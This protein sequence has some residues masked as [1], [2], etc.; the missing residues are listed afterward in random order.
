MEIKKLLEDSA[1]Y[2]MNTYNRFPIVLRKGRGMKVWS[3]DGK[4]YLDFVGGI[5][6]NCLG[7]CHP[8]VVVALQKQA[9]RLIHVS[10]YY[11]IEPQIKLAK[12]LVENSFADKVFFCNSGAEANE[13]A[14]KL[15][16]RYFREQVGVNRFRIITALNSFHGRTLATVTATGQAKFQAGFEPLVPGFTHVEFNDIDAIEKAVTKETCA[17]MIEP[18]QGEGGV[19]VPDPD[20]LRNL[21]ELCDRHG[22]LLIL[23]EVQTGIGRTGKFFAYEH[24]GIT[25]DIMTLAKGLGGGVPIGAM[26]ATDK[27]AAGFEPGTHATTFGGNPLVCAAAVAAMEVILEDGFVLDQC[28]RMGKYFQK[29]LEELKKEFPSIVAD[30]RGMGLMIGMELTRDGGP[31]VKSCMDKGLLINCTAGNVLRFIPP[32]IV[33]EKEIDHLIDALEQIFDQL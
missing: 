16:R 11:H 31:I 6:V 18:I 13:A 26:L 3:S 30:I 20:Y 28:R 2:L 27:V 14:I 9:Q 33:T 10:N 23:D 4:E 32:L 17:V 7:H 15:S 1:R 19:K 5:A 25:P 29:R 21:R 24:F 22:I 12:L 8:K